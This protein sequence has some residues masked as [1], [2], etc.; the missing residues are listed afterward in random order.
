MLNRVAVYTDRI[1]IFISLLPYEDANAEMLITNEDLAAYGILENTDNEKIAHTSDFPSEKTS[2]DSNGTRTHVSGV[3][4]HRTNH[5]TI[6]PFDCLIILA[7]NAA[8]CN[9]FVSTF[10]HRRKQVLCC[11]VNQPFCPSAF[12]YICV[13]Y[14]TFALFAIDLT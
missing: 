1:E 9:C 2:G 13:L 4:G 11:S 10:A 3:R 6:E 5:Y 14:Y 7:Q 12:Q 8:F